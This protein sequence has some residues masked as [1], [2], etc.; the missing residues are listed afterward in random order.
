MVVSSSA[1]ALALALLVGPWVAS[2]QS[3]APLRVS[4]GEDLQ[5]AIDNSTLNIVITEHLDL[6]GLQPSQSST[7]NIL[8]HLRGTTEYIQVLLF[9]I[10]NAVLEVAEGSCSNLYAISPAAFPV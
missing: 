5:A 9:T 2:G 10:R 6:R 7:S 1:V 8:L 3:T 4:T